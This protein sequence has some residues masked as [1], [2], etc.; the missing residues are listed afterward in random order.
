MDIRILDLDGSVCKQS[1]L[2][3][4]ARICSLQDI[5]PRI[6]LACTFGRF[7]DFEKTLSQRLGRSVDDALHATFFGSGDFH[8]VSLAL[9]RRSRFPINLMVIDNH[10]D[11]MRGVPFMHCGTW[12]YHAAGLPHV[13]RIYHVGGDVDFDNYYQWMGP[14]PQLR[15]GK[16]RV[17]PSRRRFS[18]GGWKHVPNE[19]IRIE[20]SAPVS[21]E[22]IK[23][24]FEP[25]RAELARRPLYISVDKDVMQEGDAIV[26]WDSGHLT[27]AEVRNI[28][29]VVRELAG[30]NLAGFDCTGDWS[31]VRL[32]GILG[33]FMHWTEHP[34]LH[35]SADEA[36]RRNNRANLGL[37]E[38]IDP[39][40]ARTRSGSSGC[41][42]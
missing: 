18:R 20:S 19:P 1:N 11:W 6:R 4:S 15:A 32:R 23:T 24:I 8:H 27:L 10:P 41:A 29:E 7:Q 16:F 42:A 34:S 31:P 38:S 21:D 17:F 28:L 37:L 13:E 3:D 12:L 5:G 2:T 9:L 39:D 22:R 14:W 30:G 36:N 40:R 33:L 26:N 25:F 35:V